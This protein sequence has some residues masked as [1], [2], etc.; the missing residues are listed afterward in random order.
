ME[1]LDVPWKKCRST[2]CALDGANGLAE[3]LGVEEAVAGRV[4]EE[5]KKREEVGKG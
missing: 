3:R 1:E 4:E 2:R 5:R